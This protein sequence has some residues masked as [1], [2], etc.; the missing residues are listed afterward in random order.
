MDGCMYVYIQTNQSK[1][2]FYCVGQDIQSFV[3]DSRSCDQFK[4]SLA[5][6]LAAQ[7][8]VCAFMCILNAE[9]GYRVR[10]KPVLFVLEYPHFVYFS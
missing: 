6:K 9:N 7:Y 4:L 2:R 8:S 1:C 10:Y 3:Q 5:Y